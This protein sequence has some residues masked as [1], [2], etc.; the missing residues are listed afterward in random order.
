M[1][2]LVEQLL[3][4]P[5]LA[6]KAAVNVIG[7]EPE[8]AEARR[9]AAEVREALLVRR[10]LSKRLPDG[11]FPAEETYSRTT[12]PNL[13]GYSLVSWG[14]MSKKTMNPFVTADALVVLRLGG[15]L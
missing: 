6:W 2:K 15:R 13:S 11:G 8:S 12:R 10:L 1:N 3:S 14:G 4:E 7:A 9:A 5:A